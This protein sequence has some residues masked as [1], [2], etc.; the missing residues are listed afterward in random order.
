[1]T[2]YL[3][4]QALAAAA[5]YDFGLYHLG[6]IH[7]AEHYSAIPGLANL[8]SRFGAGDGHLLLA[9]FLD[10]GPWAGAGPHL[11]NGLLAFLLSLELASRFFFRPVAG[12]L[13]SFTNRLALLLVPALVI[14][15]VWRPDQRIA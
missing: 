7:Y 15:V 5:D 13:A 14:V 6:L 1:A 10:H 4:N 11:V 12:G 9:A 2:L 8:Q 3:A